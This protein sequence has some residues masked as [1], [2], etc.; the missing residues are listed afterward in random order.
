[1]KKKMVVGIIA[2]ILLILTFSFVLTGQL[3]GK[4]GSNQEVFQMRGTTLM[5]YMG[6]SEVVYVPDNVRVIA[7]SAFENNDSIQKVVL[8]SKLTTIEYNAFAECDNLLEI[9]IPDSVTEIGSA[10][11]SNCK[12]L[13]D[14]SIG[15]NVEVLGSGIFAGCSSLRDLEVSPKST[16]LTCL[17]GVLLSADRSYLYQMLP[18][19]EEPYYIMNDNVEEIGQYAFWGCHNLEH[20]ILSD[21]IEMISPYA[22]SNAAGLKSV[23]MSFAV[24]EIE[25]KAFED[26]VNLE[27]IYIPDSVVKI[28]D[29][30]FDGCSKVQF[31]AEEGS[32]GRM[33][34]DKNTIGTTTNPI[35][36][37]SYANTL[38]T[39][40]LQAKK[41]AE[42]KAEQE[43]N[44]PRPIEIGPDVMGYTTIVGSQAVVLMDSEQGEVFSGSGAELNDKLREFAEGKKI[45]ANAFYGSQKIGELDIPEGVEEIEKFAFARSSVT[46]VVIPEGTTTIGYAAFYHCDDL[47]DVTIPDS[48]TYIADNAFA[49]TP[50]LENWYENGDEDYLIVGDGILLGYKGDP[51]NYVQPQNVKSIACKIP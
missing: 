4:A 13:C 36:S 32:Y 16:T 11:F 9:D 21:K 29:T 22:F 20:V 18:G 7:Q 42:E 41:E 15:K 44:A 23:S 50:W 33:Y 10:A 38:K 17:D 34:A 37:L 14:V 51:E 30:A 27:Q 45:T 6:S 3:T 1:M 49:Y 12:S 25:M 5:K 46:E 28:H 26:C 24:T 19:R 39:E 40:Y 43:A 8:P 48:V 31:Y 2:G 35:Y 47:E